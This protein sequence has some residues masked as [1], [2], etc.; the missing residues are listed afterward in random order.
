MKLFRLL[1]ISFVSVALFSCSSSPTGESAETGEATDTATASAAAKTYAVDTG[2]SIINWEGTKPGGSHIGTIELSSGSLS[3]KD[4]K[5]EAGEFVLDMKAITGT[6]EGMDDG[7]KGKL[8]GHLSSPDFFDVA[9]YPTANFVIASVVPV[10]GVEGMTH[11]IKGNFNMKEE[12]K[13]VTFNA[14]I[15]ITENGVTAESNNFKINRV[16][17]GVNYGSTNVFKDLKDGIVNDEI[18]LKVRLV[19]N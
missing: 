17:W 7:T 2:S 10:E 3:V 19:A 11:T 5:I 13:S 4:G 6:D 16:D 14:N 9:K 15:T 12:T 1:M 18:G 8:V